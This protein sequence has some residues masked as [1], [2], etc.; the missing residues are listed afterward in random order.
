MF[1]LNDSGTVIEKKNNN[2]VF[3]GGSAPLLGFTLGEG[4]EEEWG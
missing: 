4:L 1:Y 2:E 3:V